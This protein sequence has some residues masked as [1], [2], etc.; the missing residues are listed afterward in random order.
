MYLIWY[1]NKEAKKQQKS[2]YPILIETA[3]FPVKDVNRNRMVQDAL[4]FI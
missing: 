3:I 4:L 2:T 1:E